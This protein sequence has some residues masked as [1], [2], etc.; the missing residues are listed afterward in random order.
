M[1]KQIPLKEIVGFLPYELKIENSF[2]QKK[3]YFLYRTDNYETIKRLGE[4][5]KPVVR[6]LSDL[7]K[8]ITHNG[9]TFVPIWKISEL[10]FDDLD[11]KRNKT[12]G[13]IEIIMLTNDYSEEIDF[14]VGSEIIEI[15]K[16]W[17]FDVYDWIKDGLAI[18]MSE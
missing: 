14:F 12:T 15:L 6:P 5:A 18:D 1:K 9:E 7:T 16:E 4:Y 3:N 17:N 10:F 2:G 8:K 11:I 13:K